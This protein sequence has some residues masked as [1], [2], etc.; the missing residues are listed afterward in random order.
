MNN[1]KGKPKYLDEEEVKAVV[2]VIEP[3]IEG[4]KPVGMC[5]YGSRVAGYAKQDS[6]YDVLVVLEHYK[7]AVRYKYLQDDVTVS[8]LLVDAEALLQDAKR[9]KLGEFV[10]GR[11][12]N[13]YDP[14]DGAEY[15]QKIEVTYK[16]R[17]ILEALREL[18]L[19][20]GELSTILLIKPEYFLFAKLKKRAA[21]YPPAHYSYIKTYSGPYAR[22]NIEATLKGFKEALK[23]IEEEGLI[24]LIDD[25]ARVKHSGIR[26]NQMSKILAILTYASRGIT[27]YA[28]HSYAGRVGLDVVGKEIFSKISRSRSVSETPELLEQPTKALSISEGRLV[29]ECDDWVKDAK[30]HFGFD[31]LAE[32]RFKGLG[33]FYSTTQLLEITDGKRN[34]KAVVKRFKNISAFKWTLLNI[35]AIPSKKFEQN[36][37]ARMAYEYVALLKFRELGFNTPQILLLYLSD[38]ILVTEFLEGKNLGEIISH[39]LAGESDDLEPIKMYSRILA[40]LHKKGYTI[41]DT[42]PSNTLYI[43]SKLYLTDLEQAM[44][45]G[46]PSWD[47]AEFIYYAIK[48][49]PYSRRI[50][51]LI[52]TFKEGYL[53]VGEKSILT[54]AASPK[55][56]KPFQPI[57]LP[58]VVKIV[59]EELAC[60]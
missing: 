40:E 46:D 11:L 51:D 42:K 53:S 33:E 13:I 50:R 36:P 48:L 23:E 10:V 25:I 29:V 44:E 12:L 58:N 39:Y 18:A 27:Q 49:T 34:Q 56:L 4:N 5:L 3:L 1:I 55:Y 6:D 31:P 7:P 22:R 14:I 54:E 16:K 21:I 8:A 35:W 26:V 47:V 45:G 59:K 52:N 15:L 37:D 43:D 17:V 28:V 19:T 20:Y 60:K 24:N 2:K 57:I 41:G 9:A 32:T 30:Q 38:R